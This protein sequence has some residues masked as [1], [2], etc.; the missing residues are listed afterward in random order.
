MSIAIYC[1][2]SCHLEHDESTAMG[3]GSIWT[4][5]SSVRLLSA[6]LRDIKRRHNANGELKWTKVSTSRIDFYQEVV[7]WFFDNDAIHFRALIVPDKRLLDHDTFNAGSHDAFYY[8]MFF[9]LLNKI[10]SPVEQN[11]IYIDIK[12]T[13]SKFK[14]QKLKEVLC[15][16]RYD[17]TGE[18][19]SKI[20]HARSHELELMQLTDLFLGALVYAQRGLD[21]SLAKMAI[22][23]RIEAKLKRSLLVSTPLSNQ[24]FNIFV[25]RP[26][27]N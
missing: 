12:D 4:N 3:L 17:F 15:N 26:R 16:D 23:K 18:R 7:D 27:V 9:S 21:S 22:C 19:I 1:D 8:K 25:W 5:R 20:Q 2:E 14:V 6:Q 24:K 13:R 10:I 11:E